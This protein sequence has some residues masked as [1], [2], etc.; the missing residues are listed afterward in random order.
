MND[1]EKMSKEELIEKIRIL[2]KHCDYLI[3][4]N[5]VLNENYQHLLWKIYSKDIMQNVIYVPTE[6]GLPIILEA[7]KRKIKDN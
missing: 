2:E 1:Y 4:V 6:A 3:K 7:E 5:S